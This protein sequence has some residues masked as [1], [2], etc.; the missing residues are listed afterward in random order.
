M[1]ID[2]NKV[3]GSGGPLLCIIPRD[4][5]ESD[6][7]NWR[8]RIWPSALHAAQEY[9]TKI[10]FVLVAERSW[11]QPCRLRVRRNWWSHPRR[12]RLLLHLLPHN[13][14]LLPFRRQHK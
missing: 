7:D 8:S 5:I 9:P 6:H 3:H 13:L 2:F 10:G 4:T 1:A 12:H 11:G 14:R